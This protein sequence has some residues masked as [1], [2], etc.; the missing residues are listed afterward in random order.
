MCLRTLSAREGIL[1]TPERTDDLDLRSE[2]DRL[3]REIH[4]SSEFIESRWD[5]LELRAARA[6]YAALEQSIRSLAW[7][8]TVLASAVP[9]IGLTTLA[10]AIAN[11][12]SVLTVSVAIAAPITVALIAAAIAAWLKVRLGRVE[13]RRLRERT[14]ELEGRVEE[15]ST[16]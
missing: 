13:L 15:S 4:E 5:L 8:L 10:H 2:A 9:V 7:I 6:R 16:S 14:A 11:K 12:G 1:V 3:V